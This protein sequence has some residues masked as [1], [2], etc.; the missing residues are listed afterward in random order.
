MLRTLAARLSS[1]SDVVAF[2]ATPDEGSGDLALVVQRGSAATFDCGRWFKEIV[3]HH[4]GRGG[5]RAERAEG[6]LPPGAA[7]SGLAR[8]G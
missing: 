2:C 6:R 5:G 7:L 3:G 4:G 8:L 1:R